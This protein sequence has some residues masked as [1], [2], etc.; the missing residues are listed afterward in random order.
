MLRW[1]RT[2]PGG[3]VVWFAGRG[4]FFFLICLFEKHLAHRLFAK[5][6]G[7]RESCHLRG[8]GQC[9]LPGY[10]AEKSSKHVA[11]SVLPVRLM[12]ELNGK[13]CEAVLV[14]DELEYRVETHTVVHVNVEKERD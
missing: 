10:P 2:V 7:R 1:R 6:L 13:S 14:I 4:L 11:S 8:D 9:W 12:A 3:G 5:R